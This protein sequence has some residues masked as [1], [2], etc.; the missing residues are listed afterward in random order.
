MWYS[1]FGTVGS[2][3]LPSGASVSSPWY[4]YSGIDLESRLAVTS[5]GQTVS[6]SAATVRKATKGDG[7]IRSGYS[8][9][10]AGAA[11]PY[12]ASTRAVYCAAVVAVPERFSSR[13][14]PR[15]ART[16]LTWPVANAWAGDMVSVV[17]FTIGAS[18]PAVSVARSSRTGTLRRQA[19]T[20]VAL[21]QPRLA[22]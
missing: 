9:R 12:W 16:L 15:M 10:T 18:V 1:A 13:P 4:S 7:N 3:S 2:F 8:L 19:A 21:P 17:P 22:A 5:A 6:E 20:L 14:T 11:L